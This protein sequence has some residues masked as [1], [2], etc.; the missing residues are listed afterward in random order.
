VLAG[1]AVDRQRREPS[2]VVNRRWKTYDLITRCYDGISGAEF[3][4]RPGLQRIVLVAMLL[5]G[6]T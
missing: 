5:N 3:A 1:R 2:V 4:K 6:L